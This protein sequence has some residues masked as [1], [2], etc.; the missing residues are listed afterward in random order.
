M[1]DLLARESHATQVRTS[2][3]PMVL[4]SLFLIVSGIFLLAG[5]VSAESKKGFEAL[6][7]TLPKQGFVIEPE[8]T[9]E[10]LIGFQNIG[11]KSWANTGSGYVSI[12]TYD[13]K[14][15]TSDFRADDWVDYTQAALLDESSVA[16]GE[17]GHVT[18]SL[19]APKYE[20]K[21]EETFQLAAEDTAWIP[22]GEFTLYIE[23]REPAFAKATAGKQGTGNSE[24]GLGE[25]DTLEDGE[26]SPETDG[27]SAMVLLRSA[28]N[29]VADGGEEIPFKIGI[30]NTG[31][32][33]WG[34]REILDDEVAI[35]SI[36]S[37]TVKPGGLE[38]F[39][40]TLTAP[41]SKGDHTVRY[42]MAVNDTVI[43]DFYI[44]IPVEVTSGSEA[45]IDEEI[46]IE[47][48]DIA[49]D[50]L[51]DEPIM[52]IGLLTI[53]EETDWVTEIS[54]N[55]PWR[56]E[57]EEEGLLG[58]MDKDEMVRAFYK[59]QRYYFNR[60]RGIE[61]THKYLRFV[62]KDDDAVCEIENF[63][64]RESRNAAYADNT[65]RDVLELQY[66]PYKDETWVIN[67]LPMDQY[68]YG[69]AETSDYSHQ[70]F[71]KALIT[72]ARTYGVYHYERNTKHR[73][74]FHMNA[75]ADD[76]VYK[77]YEYERR[78]PSIRE[79]VD[80]VRGVTVNYDGRTA[81]TPYF[82]RSDGRTRS[83]SEV[84]YNEVAWLQGVPAPYDAAAG[85][86][87]W[88]HGVGMSATEALDMAEDGYDWE[89]ILHHFYT[90]VELNQRWE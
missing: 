62:P 78:H 79:A 20:G 52:R 17:V 8:E 56:L 83:F 14:Y 68:L 65:F 3:I 32:E 44:D 45:V 28:K 5:N 76:Q 90:D 11:E 86:S 80:E 89:E 58:L 61:Q 36:D 48:T 34:M 55:T 81:L 7:V 15:R 27:L 26:A 51:I 33:A 70:E 9:V 18:L 67:E 41:S 87:L 63:D 88:G 19:T 2:V 54:C 84:W 71:K 37:G 43:P 30:K 69:L 53:D 40:F 49:S 12:Y 59:N 57:D 74:Y 46:T 75:Y 72:V 22:G 77:G 1:K 25:E 6:Q 66:I 60:G 50:R 82:S 73:G 24:E 64:R 21:Y 31:T 42:L 10:V 35:A 23:V 39:D 4:C 13:P 16:V 29:L 38:F 85:R 47:E